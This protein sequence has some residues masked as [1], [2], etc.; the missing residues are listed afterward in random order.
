MRK[1]SVPLTS[2]KAKI[3][4]DQAEREGYDA[5]VANK[6]V[7]AN[8]H[9]SGPSWTGWRVG[10]FRAN[11]WLAIKAAQ[12][13]KS[14]VHVV[15]EECASRPRI[16]ASFETVAAAEAYIGRLEITQPDKVRRGGFGIDAPEEK[17]NS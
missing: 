14:D 15:D 6:T 4:R 12:M 9:T 16:L 17:V 7:G 10:W 13:T 2:Q 3:A 8:P 1:I 5:R 11:G